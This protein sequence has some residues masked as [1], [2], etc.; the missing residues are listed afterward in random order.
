MYQFRKLLLRPAQP[1]SGR[2]CADSEDQGQ[3]P[4]FELL[5]RPEAQYFPLGL[6]EALQSQFE[7][8]IVRGVRRIRMVGG[9]LRGQS[10][11]Q[12][13]APGPSSPLV[14]ECP[15]GD[16]VAPGK[17]A[18]VRYV[19][20]TAPNGEHDLRQG[21]LGVF[22]GDA[23]KQIALDGLE[24]LA[25]YLVESGGFIGVGAHWWFCVRMWR[26]SVIG[27][28]LWRWF[29]RGH[30]VANW[31]IRSFAFDSPLSR[32]VRIST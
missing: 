25:G 15:P 6:P 7:G 8:W 1:Q 2:V 22:S 13:K 27:A 28:K 26:D 31:Q 24:D 17:G 4:G 29:R 10:L 30:R 3:L 19:V 11:H 14:G 5:P 9:W 32:V 12:A 18:V 23:S 16:A 20:E 21:I